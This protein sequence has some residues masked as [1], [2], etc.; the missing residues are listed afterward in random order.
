M[1]NSNFFHILN[2]LGAAIGVLIAYLSYRK[3]NEKGSEKQVEAIQTK[4][5]TH[6]TKIAVLE[7]HIQN[8]KERL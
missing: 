3:S 4:L 8:L 7:A 1:N 2:G 5:N 6:E